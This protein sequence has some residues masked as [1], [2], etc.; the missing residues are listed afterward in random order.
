MSNIEQA[1]AE[2]T[3][4][5]IA[6]RPMLTGVA[7]ARDVIPN[8]KENMLLHAGPPIEWDRMSGPLRGAVIGA[9][10]FEGLATNEQAAISMVESGEIEFSPC[11]HHKTVGPMA[12]VISPSMKVYVL[13][14]VTHGT[15]AF[16][17]LNEGYGKVLRYGAY[18]EDVIDK[19]RWMNDVLAYRE[20]HVYLL[21]TAAIPLPMRNYN[22]GLVGCH[23]SCAGITCHAAKPRAATAIL[24]SGRRG[25]R[26]IPST[27]VKIV[28]DSQHPVLDDNAQRQLLPPLSRIPPP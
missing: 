20:F 9:L 19:L 8:L 3:N 12:G 23:M 17:N 15:K 7:T 11:H 6:S 21:V 25:N 14:D 10:L 27:L 4:R 18:S 28:L 16:S 22:T 2:A 1:N 26:Y 13:E 24:A 5:M